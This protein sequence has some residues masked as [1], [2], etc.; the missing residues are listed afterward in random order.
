ME[1]FINLSVDETE[2]DFDGGGAITLIPLNYIAIIRQISP[3]RFYVKDASDNEGEFHYRQ[4]A[5]SSPNALVAFFS[6]YTE[7]VSFDSGIILSE[8]VDFTSTGETEIT[9][10]TGYAFYC[11]EVGIIAE[12]TSN[13]TV[14]PNIEFGVNGDTDYYMLANDVEGLYDANDR[15]RYATQPLTKGEAVSVKAVINTAATADTLLGRFYFKGFYL[16]NNAVM[17]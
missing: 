10:A 11:D 3:E 1:Q 13:V 15:F 7:I 14:Q 9:I 16:R 2:I 4:T 17:P 6:N 5:Y 12:S 8:Q